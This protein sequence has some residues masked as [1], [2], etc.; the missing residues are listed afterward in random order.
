MN[1]VHIL[2]NQLLGTESLF[3][4]LFS[5]DC[6]E[7]PRVFF[8][9]SNRTRLYHVNPVHT[10]KSCVSETRRNI[11]SHLR[12]DLTICLFSLGFLTKLYMCI[13]GPFHSTYFFFS[14][15]LLADMYK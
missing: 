9:N 13:T 12:L 3:S 14:W 5:S 2:L 11:V 6:Q 4:I 7:I 15:I 1:P 10:L 8:C